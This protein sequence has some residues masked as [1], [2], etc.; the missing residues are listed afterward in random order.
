MYNDYFYCFGCHSSGDIIT[1]VEK[2]F[3]LQ[4]LDATKKL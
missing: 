2:L 3:G 4:P 1:L